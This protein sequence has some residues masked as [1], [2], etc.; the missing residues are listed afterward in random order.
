MREIVFQV[1]VKSMMDFVLHHEDLA[2]VDYSKNFVDL[3]G[4][5]YEHIELFQLLLDKI[6]NYYNHLVV[7]FGNNLIR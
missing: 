3:D 2:V 4:Y 7:F 6:R 1:A 5:D